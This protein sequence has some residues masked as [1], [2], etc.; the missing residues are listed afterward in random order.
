M[1]QLTEIEIIKSILTYREKVLDLIS[2]LDYNFFSYPP[3]KVIIYLLNKYV[4]KFNK[5]PNYTELKIFCKII[6]LKLICQLM[7][8]KEK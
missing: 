2:D 3:V 6:F 5:F 1:N 4:K 7:K 8:F